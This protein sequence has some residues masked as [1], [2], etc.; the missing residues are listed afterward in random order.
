MSV[1]CPREIAS[2]WENMEA[3][4]QRS[5]GGFTGCTLVAGFAQGIGNHFFTP[6]FTSV[7]VP[8]ARGRTAPGRVF[9]LL[10]LFQR[11]SGPPESRQK[12]ATVC[13]RNS[14]SKGRKL[15]ALGLSAHP[16]I[17]GPAETHFSESTS[18]GLPHVALLGLL[19]HSP[20]GLGGRVLRPT[21]DALARPSAPFYSRFAKRCAQRFQLPRTHAAASSLLLAFPPA[22]ARA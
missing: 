17:L 4:S 16:P 19:L 18:T 3:Q 9:R 5:K 6:I 8:N 15:T 10:Q 21:T 20:T 12:S 2:Y 11:I 14:A 7:L 22:F 1:S 13:L